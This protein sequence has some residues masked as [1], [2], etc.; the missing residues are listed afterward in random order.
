MTVALM[1]LIVY[2]DPHA[3]GYKGPLECGQYTAPNVISVSYTE[4]EGLCQM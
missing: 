4:G 3:G 2:P 1:I